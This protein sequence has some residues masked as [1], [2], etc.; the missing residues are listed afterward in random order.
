MG[1]VSRDQAGVGSAVN[2]AT[3]LLGGTLGVAIIGSVY[4]SLYGTRLSSRL[5]AHFPASLARL[6]H[7]SVGAALAVSGRI[8]QLGRPGLG[9]VVHDAAT[10]AFLHG[11]SAGCLVAGG[12]A[13]GGAL[14]A[15]A[16]LPAQPPAAPELEA[17]E[18]PV[19]ASVLPG[20]PD[21]P[22]A[23]AYAPVSRPRSLPPIPQA[24]AA[25]SG[26]AQLPVSRPRSLPPIATPPR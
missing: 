2:D 11:I 3:R 10:G 9:R 22:P 14:M 26:P 6:A 17:D 8:S 15:A 18:P 20:L 21:D 5:P 13:A 19:P 4:A 24:S 23:P 12:V 7:Q 1:A 16:F 25:S